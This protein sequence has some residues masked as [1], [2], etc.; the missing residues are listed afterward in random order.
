[1]VPSLALALA[2]L[3][4]AEHCTPK[5]M[6]AVACHDGAADLGEGEGKCAGAL[7]RGVGGRSAFAV[8]H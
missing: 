2:G 6:L 8:E 7:Y 3:N 5:S 1:M 4:G